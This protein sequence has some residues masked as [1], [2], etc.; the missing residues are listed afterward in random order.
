[1]E[2]LN[3]SEMADHI[4]ERASIGAVI[5]SSLGREDPDLNPEYQLLSDE[6]F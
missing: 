2:N 5:V 6:E 1:M 4:L 3:I